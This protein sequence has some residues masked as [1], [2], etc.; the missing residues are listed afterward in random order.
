MRDITFRDGC[1]V[2]L[3]DFMGS[4]ARVCDAAR[5][6]TEAWHGMTGVHD[7]ERD[8][9]LINYLVKNRHGSPFEKA[10]FEFRV[11]API[12]VAR[13]FMR[14]RFASYNEE[15]ARYKELD[16]V[17]WTPAPAR[18]LVQEGKPGH[19]V[20]KPGTI[21]LYTEVIAT[22][23]ETATVCYRRYEMML[24]LGV[25]R[26]VARAI[27]PVSIYTSF[28]VTMNARSLMNFL[29]LRI[30][31][32]DAAYPSKP[33]YEIEQVALDMQDIFRQRL[34]FTYRAFEEH[35]RVAP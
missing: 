2:E 9:G 35:G 24:S 6:S 3:V 27:L 20:M 29:S 28:Y 30:D 17:F 14:H 22:L 19:Y 11:H 7:R 13:E 23:R 16:A 10:V 33:Q 26:E 21:E 32:P 18:G 15:S 25:A 1:T 31:D 5:V 4:D 8:K 34:P 12:F